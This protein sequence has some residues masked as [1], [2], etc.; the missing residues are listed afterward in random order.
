MCV[1]VFFFHCIQCHMVSGLNSQRAEERCAPS[2]RRKRPFFTWAD[3]KSGLPQVIVW[4]GLDSDSGVLSHQLL[5]TSPH[6]SLASLYFYQGQ[7]RTV[8]REKQKQC[9]DCVDPAVT[10]FWVFF[11]A[12]VAVKKE[13]EILCTPLD[14]LRLLKL[15]DLSRCNGC[16]PTCLH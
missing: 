16:P 10:V 4:P 6:S 11:W 12:S 9:L 7:V 2:S 3:G 15:L 1:C 5:V 13:L 14:K 8:S